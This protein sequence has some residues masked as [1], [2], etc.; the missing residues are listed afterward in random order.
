[1]DPNLPTV[2]IIQEFD[3]PPARVHRAWTDPELVA[4]WLEPTGGNFRYSNWEGGE[5]I[6]AFYGSFRELRPDQRIIHTMTCE[7]TRDS[8]LLATVTFD[9]LSDWGPR[10][11]DLQRGGAGHGGGLR[12]T[13][14]PARRGRKG[15]LPAPVSTVSG[16]HRG[17]RA[18]DGQAGGKSGSIRSACWLS[19]GKALTE[20]S[21]PGSRE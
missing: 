4:R 8:V 1:M 17:G 7:G 13:G 14:R 18:T 20:T 19:C 16:R 5:K 21:S 9:D 2:R 10:H 3:P 15:A 6:A 11:D 12:A